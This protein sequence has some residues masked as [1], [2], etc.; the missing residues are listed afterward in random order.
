MMTRLHGDRWAPALITLLLV[1]SCFGSAFAGMLGYARIPY[2]AAKQGHFYEALARVHPT[3]RIPHV[4]LL[5]IGGLTLFWSFFDLGSVINVMI[6]TRI[7]EQFVAQIIGVMLLRKNRPDLPRPYR[8]W[9]YPLPCLLALTG[10]LA[11]YVTSPPI[12]IVLGL[13]TLAAGVMAF[14]IWSR[15]TGRWPFSREPAGGGPVS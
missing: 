7:V 11:L 12:Y 2:G 8:I 14:L 4:S 5:L 15:L 10:W 6:I 3:L 1:W 13:L 9:L